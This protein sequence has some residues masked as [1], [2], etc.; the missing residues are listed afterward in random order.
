MSKAVILVARKFIVQ[1]ATT[2]AA[3][4]KR[5]DIESLG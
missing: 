5:G 1:S 4:K 3:A 2:C